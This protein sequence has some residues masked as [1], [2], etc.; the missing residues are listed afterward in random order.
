MN[1]SGRGFGEKEGL[2]LECPPYSPDLAPAN[3][4]LLLELKSAVK[5][6]HF[7]DIQH[8]TNELND[9]PSKKV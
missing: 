9:I 6:V 5:G 2:V 1:H 7:E 8:V 3:F 4:M